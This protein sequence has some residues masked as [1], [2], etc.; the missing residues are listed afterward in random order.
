MSAQADQAALET[1]VLLLPPTRRD[2]E[3]TSDLLTSAGMTCVACR[4]VAQLCDEL[5]LG[6]GAVLLTEE[7]INFDGMH[8]FLKRL[9]EQ[10]SWSDLPVVMLMR[11]GVTSPAAAHMLS[12]LG[13]VTLLERP[14]PIRSVVSAVQTAVRSRLRQYVIRD[15]LEAIRLAESRSREAQVRFEAMANFI[16]QLAW[17]ADP[18]GRVVWYNERWLQYTGKTLEQM[19]ADGWE[20]VVEPAELPRVQA[21]LQVAR[22]SGESWEDTF[23]I[24]RYDGQYRWHLSRSI[25][26]RDAIT[27]VALRFG[28]NTDIT[29]E[30]ARA[31][32]RQR[33]LETERAARREAERIGRMKDE[34]LATLSHEL[35]TPLNAIFGWAQILKMGESDAGT[36]SEA[37]NV[38]DRNVRLQTQ[39]IED[40]L[41]MSR[42]VSGKVRLEVRRI[43]L[44]DVVHASLESVMPALKAKQIHL[45]STIDPAAG[46]VNG[47]PS[48]LQQVMW[49][50]LT[51]AIKFTPRGGTISVLVESAQS[52]VTIS[53]NDSGEGISADFLPQLFERFTQADASSKR[54]HGGLGLGLSIVKNL[55]E[56]HGGT[57]HADSPG[58]GQG[59][60]FVIR[61]PMYVSLE[62]NPDTTI[63]D[64][65]A[66][67][68]DCPTKLTGIKVLVVDDEADAR[69]LVRRFLVDCEAIP[70]LAASVAEARLMLREFRPDVIL[71]DIGMPGEDGYGF[72]KTLRGQGLKTPAIAL[73]AFARSEDRMR[74]IQAGYQ[75]HL[76]KPV[77]PAELIAVIASLAGRFE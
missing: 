22:A 12:S 8:E 59:A 32:E 13:N 39:L 30:R 1:R 26:F 61:L 11:G 36:V 54:K 48:R 34:F 47:D 65:S 68:D 40:L 14:A 35:R 58:K 60:T 15:Q 51:N 76:P 70:M 3:V 33:L 52:H 27:G 37:I 72:I 63:S 55:V 50:L 46:A 44:A 16:P 25:P 45:E 67:S 5:A 10:P 17:I 49:N 43:D 53:V 42:I 19:L 66:T 20:S 4:G 56:M 21:K 7:A 23:P 18:A 64:D 57:V 69:E 77:D 31:E 2:G 41:D 71:S 74:S 24:R 75:T 38:I 29:E 6:A 73:T 28:T 9:H 62:K